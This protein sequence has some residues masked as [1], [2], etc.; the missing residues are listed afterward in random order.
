[1]ARPENQEVIVLDSQGPVPACPAP[2]LWRQRS[3]AVPTRHCKGERSRR[4]K[5]VR[6]LSPS[7]MLVSR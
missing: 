1:M 7:A 2:C 5:V 6:V 3:A 4:T